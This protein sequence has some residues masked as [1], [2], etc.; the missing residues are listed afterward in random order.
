M[1]IEPVAHWW[2]PFCSITTRVLAA[3][4][5]E[6]SQAAHSLAFNKAFN[7]TDLLCNSLFATLLALWVNAYYGQINKEKTDNYRRWNLKL[8][9]KWGPRTHLQLLIITIG[10]AKD[11]ELKIFEIIT[12]SSTLFCKGHATF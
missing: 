2:K 1:V 6:K 7:L 10:A 5:S 8:K 11:N 12:W 3:T 4:F 9:L